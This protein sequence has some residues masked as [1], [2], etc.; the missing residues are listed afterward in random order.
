MDAIHLKRHYVLG[1]H[2]FDCVPFTV[3]EFVLGGRVIGCGHFALTVVHCKQ[4]LAVDHLENDEVTTRSRC[5]VVEDGQQD[6]GQDARTHF[7]LNYQVQRHREG[8]GET[9]M[10]GL[11]ACDSGVPSALLFSQPASSRTATKPGPTG[12]RPEPQARAGESSA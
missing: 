4:D 12:A 11:I 2:R 1:F 5:A 9:D 8:V 7:H 3:T 10:A 6:T